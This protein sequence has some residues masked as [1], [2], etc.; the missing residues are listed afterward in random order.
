[1]SISYCGK[2]KR[3]PGLVKRTLPLL[4]LG[5]N[6]H[7]FCDLISILSLILIIIIIIYYRSFES[8]TPSYRVIVDAASNLA[9]A[10]I[11]KSLK[12]GVLVNCNNAWLL[13]I[14]F[15]RCIHTPSTS[16]VSCVM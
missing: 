16:D 9:A 6:Q 15:P 11:Q 2:A 14:L 4:P 13:T 8:P 1:M 5:E 10:V 7:V 12:S 3:H